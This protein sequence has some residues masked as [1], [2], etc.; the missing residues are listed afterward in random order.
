MAERELPRRYRPGSRNPKFRPSGKM[1]DDRASWLRTNIGQFV[2]MRYVQSKNPDLEDPAEDNEVGPTYVLVLPRYGTRPMK[3]NITSLTLEELQM[4]R[5]FFDRLFDLAEPI[6]RARD[7][8]A[9]NA[10]DEGDDS[11]TRYYRQPP[12]YVVREGAFREDDQSIL[13][14]LKDAPDGSGDGPDS[15]G[16]VRGDGDELAPGEPEGGGSQDDGAET[17]EP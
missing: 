5:Q 10:A 2:M 15:D 1:S 14:G 7:E 13:D 3:F 17:D 11:Y 4:T 16:G 9:Q 6:V 12:Q 8:V